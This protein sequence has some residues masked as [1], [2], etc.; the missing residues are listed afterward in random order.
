[1]KK[2]VVIFFSFA[3]ASCGVD[4]VDCVKPNG[5]IVEKQIEIETFDKVNVI[6]NVSLFIRQ[7]DE[8]NIVIEADENFIDDVSLTVEDGELQI[9]GEDSCNLFR[10]YGT[11]KVVIYVPNLTII[12]SSTSGRI[13]G[14]GALVFPNLTL[15]SENQAKEDE[16][17][18]NGVFKL[19]LAC[20]YL[21]ITNDNIAKFFISGSVENLRVGFYGGDGRLEAGNLW[22][23]NVDVFHRGSNK[24]IVN[25]RQSLTGEIR[26]TGDVIA[27]NQPPVIEVESF[28]TGKLIFQE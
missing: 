12:R 11:T 6:G 5:T 8:Q 4:P 28:Y 17:Y 7:A 25:P 14:M 13:E 9:R 18:T 19:N 27:V 16:V 24:M 15:I 1:M 21:N 23:E 2:F 10:D 22:A 26:S 20:N 3:L